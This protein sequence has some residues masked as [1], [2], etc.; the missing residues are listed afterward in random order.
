MLRSYITTV[1]VLGKLELVFTKNLCN[2]LENL[3]FFAKK[4][5]HGI[6]SHTHCC[7]HA[8]PNSVTTSSCHSHK[9]L[10]YHLRVLYFSSIPFC[11]LSYIYTSLRL[12]YANTR[13]LHQKISSAFNSIIK[14]MHLVCVMEHIW[15]RRPC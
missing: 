1:C 11:C 9:L 12:C 4:T 5:C 13:G 8:L 15:R 14:E 6:T 7:R 3:L 10:I 2:L